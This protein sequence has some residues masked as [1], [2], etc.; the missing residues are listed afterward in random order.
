MLSPSSPHLLPSEHKSQLSQLANELELAN[1]HL[2]LG[3]FAINKDTNADLQRF[4]MEAVHLS[5]GIANIGDSVTLAALQGREHHASIYN[6]KAKQQT[7]TTESEKQQ[8]IRI[9]EAIDHVLT[10]ADNLLKDL[11]AYK[12]GADKHFELS[13]IEASQSYFE[14]M[15]NYTDE[16]PGFD[17]FVAVSR[18][19]V[20]IKDAIRTFVQALTM[21]LIKAI[22]AEFAAIIAARKR[23][24]V[25]DIKNYFDVSAF[26]EMLISD[27]ASISFLKELDPASYNLVRVAVVLVLYEVA[28]GS[29]SFLEDNMHEGIAAPDI[30]L[31]RGLGLKIYELSYN[32]ICY[33]D[34]VPIDRRVAAEREAQA[35][36]GKHS[37]STLQ[38]QQSTYANQPLKDG[39]EYLDRALGYYLLAVIIYIYHARDILLSVFFPSNAKDTSD[40]KHSEKNARE[41]DKFTV[42][43]D[44]ILNEQLTSRESFEVA[45][46][47]LS[48]NGSNRLLTDLCTIGACL[49]TI[50]YP[51][52]DYKMLHAEPKYFS[53]L[54]FTRNQPYLNTM[55]WIREIP[56]T[57]FSSVQARPLSHVLEGVLASNPLYGF[58]LYIQ[59]DHALSMACTLDCDL[60]I[61]L[62]SSALHTIESHVVSFTD[63]FHAHLSK[64]QPVI[65]QAG[66]FPGTI[67]TCTLLSAIHA[68]YCSATL[69]VKT[70]STSSLMYGRLYDSLSG[71]L[72]PDRADNVVFIQPDVDEST[73]PMTFKLDSGHISLL[74]LITSPYMLIVERFEAWLDSIIA[75]DKANTEK[76]RGIVTIENLSFLIYFCD[77]L[78]EHNF[79]TSIQMSLKTKIELLLSEYIEENIKYKFCD[80]SSK[81]TSWVQVV[82]KIEEVMAGGIQFIDVPTQT[83]LTYKDAEKAIK[84]CNSTIKKHFSDTMDRFFK[85]INLK[86]AIAN[87]SSIVA[88]ARIK[89]GTIGLLKKVNDVLF[90]SIRRRY[91]LFLD[92]SERCYVPSLR[93]KFSLSLEDLKKYYEGEFEK[94]KKTLPS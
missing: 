14:T 31:L 34:S 10:V 61:L 35:K 86:A 83:G 69:T 59:I 48:A 57:H 7:S 67:Y 4:V 88:V 81:D 74:K 94:L 63:T 39:C 54:E 78:L 50:F 2:L 38:P 11:Q 22:C 75:A 25:G 73:F 6:V 76:Y 5:T 32:T 52:L 23:C 65:K 13:I 66:V 70:L 26:R 92:Y 40:P 77:S 49:G 82:D 90:E 8:M 19:H 1:E 37:A 53:N 80:S 62:L 28:R 79:S 91:S 44:A 42:V 93:S 89:D 15:H 3:I 16:F 64:Q 30:N 51:V 12:H 24:K 68:M 45:I 29:I 20:Q 84:G 36:S 17:T 33:P 21:R 85:H 56:G 9:L 27:A 47:K 72:P 41:L 87:C 60:M 43:L 71:F 18:S 55:K 46:Q 58:A